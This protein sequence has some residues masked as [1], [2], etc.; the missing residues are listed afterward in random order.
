MN[1]IR[2]CFTMMLQDLFF[3][4]ID[5][6]S[7]FKEILSWKGY[8]CLGSVQYSDSKNSKTTSC[9]FNEVFLLYCLF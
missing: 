2:S 8:K 5:F 1:D 3:F 6:D 7:H 9:M 4:F